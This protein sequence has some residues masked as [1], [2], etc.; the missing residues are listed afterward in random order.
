MLHP[1]SKNKEQMAGMF[2][3]IA[4]TYDFLNHLLSL[5]TDKYWRK[6]AIKMLGSGPMEHILDL[7]TGTG[8]FAIAAMAL[9]P[10]RIT[11]VDISEEMMAVGERKVKKL[12]W[13]K[14]IEFILAPAEDLPFSG[15]S[16]SAVISAFGIRNFSD[17]KAGLSEAFRVLN[18]GGSLLILEFS[19]PGNFIIRKLFNFYFKR[20]L[21]LAGGMISGDRRAYEYLPDSVSVFPEGEQFLQLLNDAGF[22]QC[23]LNRLTGSIATVY[24][25]IKSS[26]S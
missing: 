11:G 14:E 18:T 21:P 6:Q 24:M 17:L 13:A 1:D 25:G 8:D 26:S 5:N 12:N 3:S 9:K 23:R 19:R 16:F 7:A 4:G 15:N 10:A 2:N 22:R 20:V